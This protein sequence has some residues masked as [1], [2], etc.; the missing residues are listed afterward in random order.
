[1]PLSLRLVLTRAKISLRSAVHH[2]TIA[3]MKNSHRHHKENHLLVHLNIDL[4]LHLSKR[5]MSEH[6]NYSDSVTV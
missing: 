1:M 3:T 4:Y 6:N 2:N 5:C